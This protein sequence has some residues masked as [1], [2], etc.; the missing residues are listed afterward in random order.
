MQLK[1]TKSRDHKVHKCSFNSTVFLK[2]TAHD[3]RHIHTKQTEA[4]KYDG[5]FRV[6]LI[7]NP[8][9]ISKQSCAINPK[10]NTHAILFRNDNNTGITPCK[11]AHRRHSDECLTWH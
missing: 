8:F 6:T 5:E 10:P 3:V 9:N 2:R 11:Y 7:N 1:L 4:E